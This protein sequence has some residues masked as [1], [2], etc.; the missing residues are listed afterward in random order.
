[1]PSSALEVSERDAGVAL[2]FLG[3]GALAVRAACAVGAG[4]AGSGVPQGRVDTCGI[5]I[6]TCVTCR[7][8][9]DV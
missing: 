6:R 1:M 2:G 7:I 8:M 9:G 5:N 4:A 3:A